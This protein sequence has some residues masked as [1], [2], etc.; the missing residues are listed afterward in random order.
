MM[1]IFCTHFVGGSKSH[2]QRSFIL[3]VT[4]FVVVLA[5]VQV[6]VFDLAANLL[7]ALAPVLEA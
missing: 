5:A 4:L 6:Q 2:L 1:A 3:P 7:P